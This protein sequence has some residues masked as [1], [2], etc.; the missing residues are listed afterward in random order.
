MSEIKTVVNITK[1]DFCTV[2]IKF[3]DESALVIKAVRS[4]PCCG[5]AVIKM[6]WENS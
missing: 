4:R 2:E 1:K 6:E 3:N 5:E